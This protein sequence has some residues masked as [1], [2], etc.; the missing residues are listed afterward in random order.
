MEQALAAGQQTAASSDQEI[1]DLER[2]SAEKKERVKLLVANVSLEN[3]P[4]LSDALGDIR[5]ETEAMEIE[6]RRFGSPRVR[7]ESS[8]G[9]SKRWRVRPRTTSSK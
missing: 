9:T 7:E 8:G 6:L 1:K 4:H 3:L 5:E 2:K